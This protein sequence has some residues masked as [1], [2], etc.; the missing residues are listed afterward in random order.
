[1]SSMWTADPELTWY[2]SG[3]MSGLPDGN[4][5]AFRETTARLRSLGLKIISPHEL[6]ETIEVVGVCWADYLRRDLAV[7]A[8]QCQG[9]IV[10]SGWT[11][12]KGAQLEVHVARCLGMPVLSADNLEPLV[13]LETRREYAG[14]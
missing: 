14:R 12:S 9:V 4:L 7:L 1:M 3:P 11:R 6:D 5:P 13:S 2:L 8:G 10:M